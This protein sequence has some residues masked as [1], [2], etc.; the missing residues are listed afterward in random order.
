MT[1]SPDALL[2]HLYGPAHA[3][4]QE[5]PDWRRRPPHP[6]WHHARLHLADPEWRA[7]PD[8]PSPVPVP[9]QRGASA[10]HA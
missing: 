1:P 6:E 9:A 3:W 10:R 8:W 5:F 2:Q 4:G 7:L